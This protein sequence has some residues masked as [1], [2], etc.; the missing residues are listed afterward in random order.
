[1]DK[2]RAQD[3]NQLFLEY[4]RTFESGDAEQV[5]DFYRFP[6]HYYGE[7]GAKAAVERPEFEDLVRRL[8]AFYRRLGVAQIVGAVTDTVELNERSAQVT[9]NWILLR[10][11]DGGREEVYS[12]TTRYL[13][14]EFE[15]ALKI[16]GLI[17]VDESR[18]IRD[19]LR[20][21]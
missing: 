12:A 9:L 20:R 13:V 8:L 15:D 10:D 6:L 5:A 17:A 11:G 2:S 7:T 4:R 14:S 3:I 21:R 1:M 16:D 19:A 18:R